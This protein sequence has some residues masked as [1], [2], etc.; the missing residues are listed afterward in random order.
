MLNPLNKN[1]WILV[2][3][4]ILAHPSQNL[5]PRLQ[6]IPSSSEEGGMLLRIAIYPYPKMSFSFVNYAHLTTL[7]NV[8]SSYQNPR[9][10]YGGLVLSSSYA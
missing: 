3:T 6:P 9:S 2:L 4:G 5:Q 8:I 1:F 7:Q 10:T